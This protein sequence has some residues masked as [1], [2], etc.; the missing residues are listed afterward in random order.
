MLSMSVSLKLYLSETQRTDLC[1]LFSSPLK[2]T[3]MH[4]GDL[5]GI[6]RQAANEVLL[7]PRGLQENEAYHYCPLRLGNVHHL[8]KSIYLAYNTVHP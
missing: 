8:Q 3:L 1:V 7:S 6:H 2:T 4:L 5:N